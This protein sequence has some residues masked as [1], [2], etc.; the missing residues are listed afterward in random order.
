MA[1]VRQSIGR[2]PTAGHP[3]L[4]ETLLREKVLICVKVPL[5]EKIFF[6]LSY[7]VTSLGKPSCAFGRSE[8]QR[9]IAWSKFP[10]PPVPTKCRLRQ[11]DAARG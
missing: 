10:T 6:A 4:R 2:N 3:Y 9:C 1:D 8:S 5:G 7:N 11:A